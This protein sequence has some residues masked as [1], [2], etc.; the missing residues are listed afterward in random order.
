MENRLFRGK[1]YLF[2][3]PNIHIEM[4]K[5]DLQLFLESFSEAKI[6]LSKQ[7]KV[8]V[9]CYSCDSVPVHLTEKFISKIET[10]YLDNCG[11]AN[12]LI[13]MYDLNHVLHTKAWHWI[14]CIGFQC[15]DRRF[16]CDKHKD[17][18]NQEYRKNHQRIFE[19]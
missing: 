11:Y 14:K 3:H 17:M 10:T 16:F 7:G 8:N 6:E 13:S 18:S 5:L 19:A 1:Y 4:G 15:C 12:N 2:P 9:A